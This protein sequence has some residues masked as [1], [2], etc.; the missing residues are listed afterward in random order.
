VNETVLLKQKNNGSG[1]SDCFSRQDSHW[2]SQRL[3]ELG[4]KP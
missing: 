3:L 4:V 2:R 1:S